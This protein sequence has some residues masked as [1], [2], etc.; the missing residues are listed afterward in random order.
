[1]RWA[2]YL[3]IMIFLIEVNHNRHV[4][5]CED[6]LRKGM[7]SGGNGTV[8]NGRFVLEEPFWVQRLMS[9][10]S[11]EVFTLLEKD[12][13]QRGSLMGVAAVETMGLVNIDCI[14]VLA[15]M[16]VTGVLT[17]PKSIVSILAMGTTTP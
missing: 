14:G 3:V 2:F 8:G 5:E 10:V 11:W 7:G 15:F 9:L 4:A 1:M 12:T 13:L 17:A 16:S 6:R